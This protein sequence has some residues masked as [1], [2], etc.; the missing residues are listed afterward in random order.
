LKLGRD[1]E[2]R[3]T[4]VASLIELL[5]FMKRRISYERTPTHEIFS[6]F[7][8]EYLDKTGFLEVMSRRQNRSRAETER[9]LSLI[10]L[11]EDVASEITRFFDELG[12]VTLDE[13]LKKIDFT[14]SVLSEKREKL[15]NEVPTKK[16]TLK[17]V[18][19]LFGA[20]TTIILL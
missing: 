13:Q 16:K 10:A 20:L 19:L 17:T 8:N 6:S 12:T 9:A 5:G 3:I 4:S 1:E 15:K 7:A 18:C 11:D 14:L 2:E